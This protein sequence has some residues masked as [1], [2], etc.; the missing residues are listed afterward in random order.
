MAKGLHDERYRRLMERL[1]ARRKELGL[2][3]QAVADMV[4][5]HQQNVSRFETGE[6]RLDV[7]EFLDV[8][9]ALGLTATTLLQDVRPLS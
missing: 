4:G 9:H 1:V 2:T 3:Q 5:M 6:R 8:A 7:V